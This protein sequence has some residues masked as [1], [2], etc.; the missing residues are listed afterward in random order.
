MIKVWWKRCENKCRTPEKG[1]DRV[2]CEVVD[3]KEGRSYGNVLWDE[4]L[5]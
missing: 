1:M 4:V 2:H 3:W 5:L